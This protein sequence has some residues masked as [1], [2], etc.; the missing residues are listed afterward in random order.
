M[1]FQDIIREFSSNPRDVKTIPLRNKKAVAFYVY[2]NNN[3]LFV[4]KAKYEKNS[5]RLSKARKIQKNEY[6]DMLDIYH[7]RCNGEKVSKEAGQR[8]V[9]QVYW[10]GIFSELGL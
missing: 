4:T 2:V 5:S 1:D 7:R 9:S 8:T 6:S 10:Y 3:D